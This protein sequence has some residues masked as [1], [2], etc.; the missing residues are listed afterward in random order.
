MHPGL[1][2]RSRWLTNDYPRTRI[3]FVA[4]T[5]Q[6]CADKS[7]RPATLNHVKYIEP[8]EGHSEFMNTSPFLSTVFEESSCRLTASVMGMAIIV[9]ECGGMALL[10]KRILLAEVRA[11]SPMPDERSPKYP[12]FSYNPAT[13]S[14]LYK[15]RQLHPY[16]L[17]EL[18]RI[19][20][21]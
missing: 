16:L 9:K 8:L 4:R 17:G 7:S 11:S 14:C 3:C 13:H 10:G 2:A 15:N 21:R 20:K 19:V 12:I 6:Y 5:E 18:R 1:T